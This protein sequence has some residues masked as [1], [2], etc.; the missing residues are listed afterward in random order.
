MCLHGRGTGRLKGVAHD[1]VAVTFRIIY[2]AVAALITRCFHL[3]KTPTFH[4]VRVPQQNAIKM[5]QALRPTC[6]D[7]AHPAPLLMQHANAVYWFGI[8]CGSCGTFAFLL[9]RQSTETAL[10]VSCLWAEVDREGCRK[11]RFING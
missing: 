2:S 3:N 1:N 4:G 9:V 7:E 5:K 10:A 11:I 8:C 6:A